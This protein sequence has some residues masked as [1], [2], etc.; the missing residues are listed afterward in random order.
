MRYIID[1]ERVDLFDVSIV[2]TMTVRLESDVPFDVLKDAFFKACESHEVL[3]SK[4]V[5]EPSGE[6][7]YV[8]N[9]TVASSFSQTELSLY[10]LI[11][12]N[13]RKRFRLE[14]GEFIRGFLSPDG[15]VFMMH[16]LG[17][18]GKSLL[19]FIETFM[20]CLAGNK[21]G[22]V[23]FKKLG[24]DDLPKDSKIPFLYTTLT[25]SWNRGWLKE[26]R[27]FDFDDMDE[28]YAK[29]WK[30]HR[31][32]VEVRKYEKEDLDALLKRAKDSG[33]TLTAYIITDM[34]KD[35][36]K[37]MD[38]GL[39]V[40]GRTDGNRSMGNQA[41]GI[42]VTYRYD[43]NKSFEENAAK[44]QDLMQK[45]LS[46]D[47]YRFF[48]L[49]FMGKLDPTLKDSLNLEHA[50]CFS[51][52]TS[53]KVADILG[54]G[55]KVKDISITNLTRA[56]IPLEYGEYKIRDIAFIPPVVSY[57][58]NVIGIVTAGDV[59]NITRHT[60]QEVDK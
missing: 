8:D 24:L 58:A 20:N 57:A 7:Y 34:I 42:S 18:D 3:K 27:I 31:S 45:K 2:I 25:K 14:D 50:G 15:I 22:E 36:T 48:V 46:D 54:Y 33:T 38:I 43:K 44:I 10:E 30:K 32:N 51:G 59:M 16:H 39:A 11:Y 29:F 9:G 23:P 13:E 5:I 21:C 52:K 26:K 1:T 6:A 41:T 37:K 12:E 49:D 56:D 53:K 55:E 35:S 40:D 17:G 19:Y 28:A 4:V 47:R 60:V